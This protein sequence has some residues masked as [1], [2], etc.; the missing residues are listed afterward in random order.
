MKV[1]VCSST[2][3]GHYIVETFL[4]DPR[5]EH[6]YH[7][8]AHPNLHFPSERYTPIGTLSSDK[9]EREKM[10]LDSIDIPGIDLAITTQLGFQLWTEFQQKLEEKK[11]PYITPN[12]HI[13]SMEWSKVYSKKVFEELDIPTPKYSIVKGHELI[14]KF[15]TFKRPFV[16]KY[17]Q[18]YRLGRQTLIITDENYEEELD[19]FMNWNGFKWFIRSMYKNDYI[20]K[21]Y[22]IE[23][24]VESTREYS[25]HA[26]VNSSG[27][28]FIGAARDYK[29]MYENDIGPLTD[30]MGCYAHV[31]IDPIVHEYANKI[32][33]YFKEQNIEYKGFM[34][35][36]ILVDKDGK[37]WVLEINTRLGE[38]EGI[39]L[40]SL[41]ENSI[42]D[43][44]Y[45][46]AKNQPIPEI[47]FL[48]KKSLCIR[49][50]NKY[51]PRINQR[52]PCKSAT[53]S[54][55]PDHIS[56]YKSS[57]ALVV[58]PIT[59]S[60]VADNLDDCRDKLYEYLAKQDTGDFYY[61][62]DI[63]QI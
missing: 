43:L 12:K 23:E 35:L 5:I 24:Y 63:G 57:N 41:I 29:N 7:L 20:N 56:M 26:V 17:D 51:F 48:Q 58:N 44:L 46:V 1:L 11:I 60:T 34:Y 2:P 3:N 19:R 6:V 61:R 21:D 37:P 53:I 8:D 27:L 32:F 59:F 31:D 16:L 25:Y 39:G 18:D 36:G 14:E 55:P 30:G 9:D 47:K 52:L 49:L 42:P 22:I 40:L 54:D 38:P 45:T 13:G 62:T 50:M 33:N 15:P 28:Q 10:I 4:K